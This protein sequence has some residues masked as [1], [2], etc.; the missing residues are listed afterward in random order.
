MTS[1]TDQLLSISPISSTNN[2]KEI[3]EFYEKIET[4]V[5]NL[6][7]DIG[8]SQYDPVLISIVKLKLPEDI[9]LQISRSTPISRE[10]DVDELLAPL[11]KCFL[12]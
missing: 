1:H 11:Q 6:F 3:R 10:W 8:T 7:L 9:K 12:S 4:N 5:Q 2:I